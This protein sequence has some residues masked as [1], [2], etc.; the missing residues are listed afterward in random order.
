MKKL[1]FIFA[2]LVGACQT[3]VQNLEIPFDNRLVVTAFISP[4]DTLLTVRVQNSKPISGTVSSN[5]TIA[6]ASVTISEGSKSV[7]LPYKNDAYSTSARNLPIRA[8]A[9]YALNV[10][11]PDGR[12]VSAQCT[13][14]NKTVN[15]AEVTTT[16][17]IVNTNRRNIRVSWRDIAN[18]NNYYV[19]SGTYDK[20]NPN[21]NFTTTYVDD[22]QRDGQIISLSTN[23]DLP[24]G[25]GS[26]NY[27]LGI[28]NF[29][30]NGY[31]YLS[32]A[33]EQDKVNGIPFT[34]PVQVYSNI[35]GGYGVFSG[36]NQVRVNLKLF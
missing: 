32:S 20:I 19:F 13:I 7:I 1:L 11:T 2:V 5:T 10:S 3:E 12:K 30:T 15:S 24:C 16:I 9:T 21:C 26:P 17:S 33:T 25:N 22:K 14:P 18:E 29:D 35:R 27:I 34:D 23:T 28:A 8:G 6:D 31:L 36:F 4:Q